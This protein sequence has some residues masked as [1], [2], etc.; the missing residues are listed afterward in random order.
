MNMVNI[1]ASVGDEVAGS[2]HPDVLEIA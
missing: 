1:D 2:E